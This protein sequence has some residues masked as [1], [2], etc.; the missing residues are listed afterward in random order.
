MPFANAPLP[1]PIESA[2]AL[3]EAL[4]ALHREHDALRIANDHANQL[5]EALEALLNVGLEDDAFASVFA[6]LHKVFTFTHAL[7]LAERRNGGMEAVVA[8]PVHLA[9]SHWPVGAFFRKVMEGRVVTT[10]TNEGLEEWQ[11]ADVLGLASAQ[12]ALYAPLR[13]RNRRG[14]LMLLRAPGEGGFDRT[15]VALA[16]KFSVLAS[17]ALAARYATQSEAESASLRALTEQLQRSEQGAKRNADLLNEVV[18]L[19]PVGVTVQDEAGRFI[20]VNDAAAQLWQRPASE[21][22]GVAPYSLLPDDAA[23]R[24]RQCDLDRM[25]SGRIGSEEQGVRVGGDTVTLLSSYKPVRIFDEMLLLS[26]SLDI[27]ERKRFE[28]ELSHLAFHDPMTGLPNRALM[29][30]IVD[31]ALQSHQRGGMFALA[32][33]DLDNFKQ[34]NDYYSH[35]IGDAL[36]MA[37]ATR[38]SE[39]MRSADTLARISGDEFLLLINP[40][41]RQH[42]L[43]PLID[44]VVEALKQPFAIEGIEILTSASVGVSVYPL[45]G[46]TYEA[47]R[48]CA[49]SAM[50]RAKNERKGGVTY[51]DISM[52]TALTAR[53]ELEQRLRNAIRDKHFRCAYQ[54][55]VAVRSGRVAGFEALIRWVEPDGTVHMPGVFIERVTELGLLDDITNFAFDDVCKDLAS[56]QQRFGSDIG[57]SINVGARQ[58]GDIRFM[59]AFIARV[60]DSGIAGNLILELTEDALV[61][62]Q[63]FQ[64]Q[65][66]P[67]LREMGVRVS[68]DDFGSGYSSLSTLADIT[69]D[70]VKVDRAFITAI[71][72]RPRSQGILKAIESLCRALGISTVAEGVETAE[73][74]EYLRTHTEIGLVQGYYFSRPE[75]ADVLC[76]RADE[77]AHALAAQA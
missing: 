14:I 13:V 31:T 68:I 67:R 60:D 39:N 15:H 34:V 32:F 3:R 73:E 42:D 50:Y 71:H 63:R 33:I 58:A 59:E 76:R 66:L 4:V 53:M 54:P 21:L 17:H 1:A 43:P 46:R 41:E 9:G 8:D 75:F 10:F 26:T 49:D 20:L 16:R 38:I 24:M 47:L 35:A 77:S 2:E 30:E 51:F 65:V 29:Q 12:S 11:N 25:H 61:A 64:M 69:A 36:L 5:L 57:V 62:T 55:K 23:R 48:R 74:L 19:L 22:R 70:E 45:H 44:A 72:Q 7:A 28:E 6:A 56:L 52:G 18:N 37:V 27:T 40:L